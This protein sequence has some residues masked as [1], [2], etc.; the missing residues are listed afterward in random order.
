MLTFALTHLNLNSSVW[1]GKISP[2]IIALLLRGL[3]GPDWECWDQIYLLSQSLKIVCR[4]RG[5]KVWPAIVTVPGEQRG[6]CPFQVSSSA[7]ISVLIESPLL[8]WANIYGF[9]NKNFLDFKI[10]DSPPF[11]L[12]CENNH[13]FS[14][15]V[16]FW[17]NIG[18]LL[19]LK[20]ACMLYLNS[21]LS[22]FSVCTFFCLFVFLN[23]WEKTVC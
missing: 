5:T 15:E 19:I 2:F 7:S 10:N 18:M 21:H 20:L 23:Y 16:T 11:F 17:K 14:I 22:R 6:H 13:F 4:T 8:N 12:N 9:K 3:P 1:F